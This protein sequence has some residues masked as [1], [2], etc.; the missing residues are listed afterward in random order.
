MHREIRAKPVGHLGLRRTSQ[1]ETTVIRP[2]NDA[3]LIV[4]CHTQ[5][6]VQFVVGRRPTERQRMMLRERRREKSINV[7]IKLRT[8]RVRLPKIRERSERT[9]REGGRA[10]LALQRWSPAGLINTKPVAV[11][12]AACARPTTLGGDDDGTVRRIDAIQR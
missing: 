12:N 5:P 10:V 1:V 9:G 7:V 11:L 2:G 6:I 4:G 8:G 3:L